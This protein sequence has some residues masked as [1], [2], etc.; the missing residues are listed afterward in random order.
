MQTKRTLARKDAAKIAFEGI[1]E[2]KGFGGVDE[3]V[4]A[5]KADG[6]AVAAKRNIVD[7]FEA[8]FTIEIRIAPVYPRREGVGN[9]EVW[10]R[11]DRREIK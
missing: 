4:I 6:M 1:E 8:R 10:L 5:A 7:Q 3:I 9:F 11:G 2:R